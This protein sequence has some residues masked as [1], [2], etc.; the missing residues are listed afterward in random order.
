MIFLKGTCQKY[1]PMAKTCTIIFAPP[2][3]VKAIVQASCIKTNSLLLQ[4]S[5]ILADIDPLNGKTDHNK[6][7]KRHLGFD[8]D[9]H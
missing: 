9:Y 1:S 2:S 3:L 6:S 8:V 4:L 5:C 7:C